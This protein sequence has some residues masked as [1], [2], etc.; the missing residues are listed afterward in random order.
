MNEVINVDPNHSA[1]G[2]SVAVALFVSVFAV[3]GLV[4]V[5]KAFRIVRRRCDPHAPRYAHPTH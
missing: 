2:R 5:V 1:R 3:A 4:L